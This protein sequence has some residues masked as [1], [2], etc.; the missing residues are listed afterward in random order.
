[1]FGKVSETELITDDDQMPS[2]A[3]W[4]HG[5]VGVELRRWRSKCD[6]KKPPKHKEQTPKGNDVLEQDPH[7]LG[8]LQVAMRDKLEVV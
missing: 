5:C 8:E 1:M 2:W 4:V 6:T 3:Y 7:K